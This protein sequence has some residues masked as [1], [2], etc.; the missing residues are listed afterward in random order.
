MLIA[1]P[2]HA[3]AAQEA[4]PEAVVVVEERQQPPEPEFID[5]EVTV[6]EEVEDLV[7]PADEESKT[8]L[9]TRP[10]PSPTTLTWPAAPSHRR[11][12]SRWWPCSK[13]RAS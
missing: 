1:R 8:A 2:M 13:A 4:A 9:P 10:P 6:S 7:S 3:A 5:V 12:S 11:V